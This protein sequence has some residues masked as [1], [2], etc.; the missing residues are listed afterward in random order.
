MMVW[1]EILQVLGF[2]L[3]LFLQGVLLPSE[4][5]F[6]FEMAADSWSSLY[7]W[8]QKAKQRFLVERDFVTW[9]DSTKIVT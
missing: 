8:S 4:E 3:I 1:L 9:I 2:D 5:A 7:L 6:V